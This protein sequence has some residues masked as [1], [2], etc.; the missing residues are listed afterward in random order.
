MTSLQHERSGLRPDWRCY[1]LH[2]SPSMPGTSF[3]DWYCRLYGV[4]TWAYRRRR[5]T[6]FI[7]VVLG[8]TV[9]EGLIRIIH[10]VWR[11]TH[12]Y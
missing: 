12:G 9:T 2:C 6:Q 10:Y 11:P 3:G 4:R 7:A 8:D 5:V 1:C